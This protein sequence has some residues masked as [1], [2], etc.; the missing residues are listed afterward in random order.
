MKKIV[1]LVVL[2]IAFQAQAEN[3]VYSRDKALMYD[4]DSIVRKGIFA[5]M[6]L[7]E[8][9]S[10]RFDCVKGGFLRISS[11]TAMQEGWRE[12]HKGFPIDEALTAA[13]SKQWEFWKR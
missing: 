7:S 8:F 10:V 9:G 12:V 6:N 2:T 5:E 11:P 3:W 1:L 4:T 13:C